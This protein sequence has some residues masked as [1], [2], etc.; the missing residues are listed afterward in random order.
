M[1]VGGWPLRSRTLPGSSLGMRTLAV[2]FGGSSAE[3]SKRSP[4]WRQPVVMGPRTQWYAPAA[5][6]SS[7]PGCERSSSRRRGRRLTRRHRRTR[8]R[9]SPAAPRTRGRPLADRWPP[10]FPPSTRRRVP[11]TPWRGARAACCRHPGASQSL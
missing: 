5:Q 4:D 1:S 11:S 6:R 3:N 2:T 7:P 10:R 9:C 8:R